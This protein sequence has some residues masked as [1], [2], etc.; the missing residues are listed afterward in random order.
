MA[1]YSYRPLSHDGEIR[2]IRIFTEH[3]DPKFASGPIHCALEHVR[4][5]NSQLSPNLTL[6]EA[7]KGHDGA[8]PPAATEY[9]VG[10]SCMKKRDKATH[11]W[12]KKELDNKRLAE[13]EKINAAIAFENVT[14]SLATREKSLPWRY[15]WG[16]Y[17]ALS[18][19]WGDEKDT[20]EIYLDG[21]RVT[22]R[23]NLEAALVQLRKYPRIQQGFRIWVDALCINQDDVEER[24][25]QVAIMKDIYASAWHV[26]V[27]LGP[28]AN[29]SNLAITAMQYLSLRMNDPDP[30]QHIY[31][32]VDRVNIEW[33]VFRYRQSYGKVIVKKAVIRAIY[34]LLTRPYWRRLWIL[35]EVARGRRG[36][37]VLC[38]SRCISLRDIYQALKVI[39]IDGNAL[40]HV[41]ISSVKNYGVMEKS[42]DS[43]LGDTYGISEKLWE[44]PIEMI[45]L[46]QQ[47]DQSPALY[48]G[49]LGAFLL[50]RDAFASDQRDRVYGILG[51]PCLS[52]LVSIW[53]DYFV[54]PNETFMS[55]SQTLFASG[56]L[57]G[58]R[59]V[60]SPVPSIG[61]RY[62]K[63][64]N[65]WPKR[66][67]HLRR[68][69]A[70]NAGCTHGLPSW[71]ICWICPSNPAFPFPVRDN[72]QMIT[73]TLGKPVFDTNG[74]FM[75]TKA[76]LFDTITS[77]SSFHSTE[78]DN[79]YPQNGPRRQS[80]YGDDNAT[81][82]ALWRTLVANMTSSGATA[83]DSYAALLSPTLWA[84]GTHGVGT[85]RWLFGMNDFYWKNKQMILFDRSIKSI[86]QIKKWPNMMPMPFGD[87]EKLGHEACLWAM[88]LLAWRRLV[89]T[90][91]GYLGLVPAAT[92][93]GDCIAVVPGCSIPLVLR[94]EEE[95]FRVIGECY[96]HGIM[97]GEVMALLD[98]GDV[99][100]TDITLF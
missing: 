71:V 41:I 26:T 13:E 68:H 24:A 31:R 99:E 81:N 65:T 37:P 32:R 7:V 56:D 9:F 40:G 87:N 48:E 58:L 80:I 10:S 3:D 96:V 17:I 35:Q 100:M 91:K 14:K 70:V 18:Y 20:A 34:H 52:N 36:L 16:D 23:A 59:L 83:P 54:T 60:N 2:V 33:G 22:I 86:I 53:P 79:S 64:L 51:I 62:F 25:R 72:H 76:I 97:L 30:L 8:W 11:L 92:L 67:K 98:G 12:K 6:G 50:S 61:T 47:E 29:N 66:P 42:W 77:L 85:K 27:W 75:T 55:F 57:N 5:D 28:E 90:D 49:P 43:T 4:F 21:I 95:M 63:F 38:G 88:R 45:E 19:V 44:R 69:V 94:R 78:S 93:A 73:G 84:Y 1:Q 15:N 46:Q 89:T 82:E 74:E 39:T